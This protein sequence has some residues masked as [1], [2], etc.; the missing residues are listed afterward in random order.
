MNNNSKPYHERVWLIK[1][2]LIPGLVG[3]HMEIW[4]PAIRFMA[5]KK[6]KPKTKK[7]KSEQKIAQ[8]LNRNIDYNFGHV[9]ANVSLFIFLEWNLE[10]QLVFFRPQV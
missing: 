8:I 6:K 1:I 10:R 5:K 2:I 4:F 9:N 3:Q 7:P